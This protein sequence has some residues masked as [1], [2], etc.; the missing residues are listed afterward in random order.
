MT[1]R[2][3]DD[4][5]ASFVE[6]ASVGEAPTRI[7]YWTGVS[8]VAGALRRRVWIDQVFFSWVPNFYIVFVAEPGIIAKSTTANIGMD[9]LRQV[10]GV[11][12]GP[13]IV[14]W[15][16]LISKMGEIG[17]EFTV[18]DDFYPMAAMT[19]AIDELGT[20]LDPANREQV[21]VLTDLWD[22]KRR[23][24]WKATKTMGEDHLKWPWLNI[25]ACTTPGWAGGNFPESF[26][27]SGFFSR[28]IFIFGAEKR[29][30]ISYISE[31]IPP[32]H[33]ET[34]RKLVEDLRAIA[35]IS[36]PFKLTAAAI[37]WGTEW[38][39]TYWK[40]NPHDAREMLGYPARK[41]THMHKLAMVISASR[42]D[43]PV[44]DKEHLVE[45]NKQLLA[46][47][48]D[49]FR[50]FDVIGTTG[51]SR[52]QMDIVEVVEKAGKTMTLTEIYGRFFFRRMSLKDF[53]EAV[54][55]VIGAG[56]LRPA[57]V[58]D[59]PALQGKVVKS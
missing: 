1:S 57:K 3:F 52:A 2:H 32:G 24:I 54:K 49:I 47:E 42:G 16:T 31:S 18:G 51:L 40:S 39:E 6:Y 7:L 48:P 58:G 22:G 15:Q 29:S 25:I 34:A 44:I 56:R 50:V 10:P 55:G 4:F 11:N 8:T 38:Y 12:F 21:D 26:L 46:V 59:S 13:D 5:L 9:L 45:A 28:V 37:K 17:E 53:N 27:K 23:D 41:Q 33:A 43:H 36:G 35:S 14:N 30:Y 20:F 19:I